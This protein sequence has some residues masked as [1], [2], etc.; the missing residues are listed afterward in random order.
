MSV[1]Y[2]EVSNGE[3]TFLL[4]RSRSSI[5]EPSGNEVV[6]G[7]LAQSE[8]SLEIQADVIRKEMKLHFSWA[9]AA[10]LTDEEIALFL[11]LCREVVGRIDPHAVRASEYSCDDDNVGYC[12][13]DS[14]A[15]D[16]LMARCSDYFLPTQLEALRRFVDSHSEDSA[17]MALV[18]RRVVTIEPQAK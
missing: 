12:K 4:R 8:P 14:A 16:E 11:E 13:P 3:D 1:G 10:P 2:V 6:N 9:P 15:V 7:R 18:R 5:E 17:V